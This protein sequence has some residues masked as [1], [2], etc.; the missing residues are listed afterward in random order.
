[1]EKVAVP[2]PLLTILKSEN[3]WENISLKWEWREK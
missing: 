2:Q 1:M 3:K